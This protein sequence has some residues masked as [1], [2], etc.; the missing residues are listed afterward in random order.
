MPVP[1]TFSDLST[2]PGSNSGL[3]SDATAVSVIDD[4]F[5]TVYALI[6]SVYLN[7]GNGWSAPYLT[8][9]NPYYT[10]TLTGG[11][12]VVNLGSGQFYK[13]GSG[14]V[15]FGT[16]PTSKLHVAGPLALSAPTYVNTASY[17]VL[18]TDSCMRFATTCTVTLPDPATC[19]GRILRLANIGAIAVTSASSN[20]AQLATGSAS[21]TILP[22][23]V[24]KWVD[25]QSD[26]SFWYA[27]GGN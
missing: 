27:T 14:N 16:V 23:V 11:T 7:S 21:S 3:I 10:G 6:A 18:S 20:V 2:T 24:G 5:R 12:G 4:H 13:D 22:A 19:I 9:S 17:T 15:G 25:I 1:S 8:A 26:G